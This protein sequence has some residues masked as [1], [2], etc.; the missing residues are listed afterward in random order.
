MIILSM[1]PVLRYNQKNIKRFDKIGLYTV[2]SV[3]CI[4]AI[5]ALIQIP[6][7]FAH[8][9]EGL[10]TILS[11][12]S[13]GLD[14]YTEVMAE[15]QRSLG[16][17]AI[18]NLPSIIVNIFTEIVIIFVFYNLAVGRKKKFSAIILILICILPFSHLANSQRGPA[19]AVIA[20]LIISYFSLN[21]FYGDRIKRAMRIFAV[22]MVILVTIPILAISHSRFDRSEG[23]MESSLVDY[24]GQENINFDVYAFDNNGLR[25]G[26]RTFPMIKRML[27]F[28]NVPNNFWERRFKYK[29]LKINDE[30]FIGYVGDFCLDFGPLIT[31]LIFV[32]ATILFSKMTKIRNNTVKIEQLLV[33]QFLM[34]LGIQG[35][36][37]LYP[38]ADSAGLK[39]FAFILI[40][41]CIKLERNYIIDYTLHKRNVRQKQIS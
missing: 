7:N 8:I 34:V 33:L 6:V 41:I 37:K 28:D 35:G 23:G 17:G 10:G 32:I 24:L 26:D 29:N 40:Y 21:S 38:Y 19:F 2:D 30:I 39:L 12:T 9:Q 11:S 15:S 5:A 36:M 16:D 27:G 22:V 13:G 18:T 25:Y 1:S 31:V 3:C 20:T 4:F 14:V